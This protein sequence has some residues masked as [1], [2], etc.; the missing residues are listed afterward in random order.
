MAFPI[1]KK[2]QRG[3]CPLKGPCLQDMS[4]TVGIFD[5]PNPGLE[6]GRRKSLLYRLFVAEP[7]LYHIEPIPA[8]PPSF[9]T[10]IL[11]RALHD[12]G[13]STHTEYPV[14]DPAVIEGIMDT[15]SR[16]HFCPGE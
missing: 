14:D 9:P 15:V 13:I 4:P 5:F 16:T 10:N 7:E 2:N 3:T 6:I 1:S 8:P 12:A 11:E